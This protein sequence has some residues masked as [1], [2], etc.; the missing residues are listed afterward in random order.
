MNEAKAVI[1][2]RGLRR[3]FKTRKETVEAVAAA[4]LAESVRQDKPGSR[5]RRWAGGSRDR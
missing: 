4:C 3:V 1:E 5:L 2:T